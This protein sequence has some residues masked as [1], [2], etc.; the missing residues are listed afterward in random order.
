M[1]FLMLFVCPKCSTPVTLVDQDGKP[2]GI[3]TEKVAKAYPIVM[4]KPLDPWL[5]IYR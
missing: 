3:K 4:L 2:Y 5:M 1:V